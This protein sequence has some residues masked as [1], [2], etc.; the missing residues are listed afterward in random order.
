MT[1]RSAV[2]ALVLLGAV[3]FLGCRKIPLTPRSPVPSG[4]AIL[5]FT[6]KVHGPFE[7]SIDGTRIPVAQSPKGAESLVVKGLAPGRHRFFLSS[8]REIFSPDLADLD[9]P[10]DKGIYQI[11]LT[12]KFEAVLYGQP[13]PLPPAE[14]LPGVSAALI[15]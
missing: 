2:P 7:L 13:D 3:S 10:A 14:G 8:A 5:R 9:M 11:V 6:R 15:K 1:F 12:Q 4:T